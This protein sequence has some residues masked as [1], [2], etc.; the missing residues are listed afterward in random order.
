VATYRIV[1]HQGQATLADSTVS[2]T[3]GGRAVVGG[4]DGEAAPYIFVIVEPDSPDGTP[5]RFSEDLDI[6]QPVA[7][8]KVMPRYPEEARKARLTGLVVL[9]T[10]IDG[11]GKVKGT[12]ILDSPAPNLAD[13]A[14]EAIRQWRFEPARMPD[15]SA[16]EVRFVLTIKFALE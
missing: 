11:N 1:F 12:R 15:G 16:V 13:A 6:S 5:L 3:R 10:V 4:M 14:L 8:D 7:I 9:E 2:V